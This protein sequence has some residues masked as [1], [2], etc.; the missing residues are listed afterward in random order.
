MLLFLYITICYI[1]FQAPNHLLD[2]RNSSNSA[3]LFTLWNARP[4]AVFSP[5]LLQPRI[6]L[7]AVLGYLKSSNT[8]SHFYYPSPIRSIF[9]A[10]FLWPHTWLL[11][12]VS[13]IVGAGAALIWTGQG[14]YLTLM[15]DTIISRNSGIFWA[16]LQSRSG[17]AYDHCSLNSLVNFK[18]F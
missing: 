1:I 5:H 9:I 2:Y 3:H 18:Y 6:P 16:M 11:Y 8:C 4:V 14:N 15:S 7:P 13:V 10:S 12:L 17:E